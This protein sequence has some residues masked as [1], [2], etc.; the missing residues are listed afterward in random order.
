MTNEK[1]TYQKEGASAPVQGYR[2]VAGLRESRGSGRWNQGQ[3]EERRVLRVAAAAELLADVMTGHAP[4]WALK[5]AIAPSW[6]GQSDVALRNNYPELYPQ[7]AVRETY[8]SSDFPF[9]L[10]D[11]LDRMMLANFNSMG[12]NWRAYCRVSR[13]L[14]DFR[15]VRRLAFNGAEGQYDKQVEGE[16]VK[17]STTLDEDNYTYAP[18]IYSKGVKLTF[19]AIM[20]DDLDAFDT[21]PER[22]GKGGRRTIEKFVTELFFD[23]NGPD[24]TFFSSGNGN[25][26]TSNPDLAI[27]ALGTAFETLLGFKDA[28][29]E[30]ILVEGVTL[31]Y[32]PALHVA[33]QNLLNQLTVD[34][35]TEGGVSGQTVRVNNWIVR[36][37]SAVMNP[38]IPI[39]ATTNG[40]T[41]WA[42]FANPSVGRPAGEVGFL[43]GFEQP[44]L[45][46]KASN[47]SVVGGGIDQMMGDFE[48]MDQH[49]KGVIALGGAVLDPKSAVASNGS[50]S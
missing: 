2:P 7:T 1:E 25:R 43:A 30:P 37:L 6:R 48:T 45:Y 13:P 18:D 9:L 32:P 36:N 14:R 8:S 24:A 4:S 35:T 16:P 46:Q 20:N 38:Y 27:D 50:N 23:A 31:V 28:D 34:V 22:L 44:R 42:L 3:L 47:A 49:Y 10:G 39:V 41:S 12:H 11:V 19:R 26:L 21:I 33:V 17:Y 29:N 40:N 5:E 15:T